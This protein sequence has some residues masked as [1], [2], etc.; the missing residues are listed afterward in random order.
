VDFPVAVWL[1]GDFRVEF[2][3]GN[4]QFGYRDDPLSSVYWA[5]FSR[6][7]HV[8]RRVLNQ[9]NGAAIFRYRR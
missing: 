1:L 6:T 7:N 8:P 3:A 2:V 4:D 5:Q 9:Q